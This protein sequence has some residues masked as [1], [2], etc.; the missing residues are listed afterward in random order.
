MDFVNDRPDRAPLLGAIEAFPVDR[1]TCTQNEH[2]SPLGHTNLTDANIEATHAF[3]P[4]AP[5]RLVP[6][7]IPN[8]LL[9][10]PLISFKNAR[11]TP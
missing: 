1:T 9:H 3:L 2:C 6:L 11:T 5:D 8:P 4:R 10:N 7:G